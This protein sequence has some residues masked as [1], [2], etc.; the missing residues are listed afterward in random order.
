VLLRNSLERHG[1]LQ[2][3][4]IGNADTPHRF[5]S[6]AAMTDEQYRGLLLHIRILIALAGFIV[7]ILLAFAWEYL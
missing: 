4:P 3:T 6:I 1:N 2:G 7:G 5:Q